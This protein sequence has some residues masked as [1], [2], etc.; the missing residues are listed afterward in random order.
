MYDFAVALRFFHQFRFLE[1]LWRFPHRPVWSGQQT[2]LSNWGLSLRR[3]TERH[4]GWIIEEHGQTVCYR[5]HIE[6]HPVYKSQGAAI[7]DFA[8]CV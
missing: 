4:T 3:W 7:K 5:M 2:L 8:T 6:L 1:N